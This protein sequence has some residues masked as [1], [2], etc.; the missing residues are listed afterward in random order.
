M[1]AKNNE[2]I[3][4]VTLAKILNLSERH[5]RRLAEENVIKKNGQNKYLF[6]ES[7]HSYLDYLELKNDADVDLKEEKIKE[8][9]K[10]IKKDT[11]LKALKISELKNQLHSATVIEEV[12]TNMLVNIK[13]KLLSLPNKLAPTVIACDNLGEIQDIILTG[14]SDTLTEL[15]EYSPDIFKNK[16][17]IDEDEEEEKVNIKNKKEN[18]N[19][20]PKKRGRPKKSK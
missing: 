8:E 9:I 12:M 16:N 13:G 19:D 3:K 1:E 4:G 11:E 20:K 18:E 7:I 17:F 2:V 15:S 5:L 6:L 14:I 10:K